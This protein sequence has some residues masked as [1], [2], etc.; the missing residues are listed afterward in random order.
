LS[1]PLSLS[2]IELIKNVDFVKTKFT[3][4]D[5]ILTYLIF[6]LSGITFFTQRKSFLLIA[7]LVM[8]LFFIKKNK[9]ID[10]VFFFI[11]FFQILI[12][13]GQLLFFQSFTAESFIGNLILWLLP[14]FYIKVSGLKF[15]KIYVDLMFIFTLIGFV[16]WIGINLSPS[17]LDLLDKMVKDLKLDPV[18]LENFIIYNTEH[19]RTGDIM[20][21]NPGP[22]NEGGTYATYLS[23]AIVLNLVQTGRLFDKRNIVFLIALLT[24][25]SSAGYIAFFFIISTYFLVNKKISFKVF[26]FPIIVGI[27]I[28]GFL[29][30]EFLSNKIIK[31]YESQTIGNPNLYRVGRFG[32]MIADIEQLQKYPIF[33][34]GIYTDDRYYSYTDILV[35]RTS[36]PM[37]ILA[38]TTRYG[39]IFGLIYFSTIF[40]SLKRINNLK[41]NNAFLVLVAFGGL[42]IT[43]SG[44]NPFLSSAYISLFYLYFYSDKPKISK[45]V[46]GLLNDNVNHNTKL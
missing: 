19:F 43:G 6:A 29:S 24:T 33:G 12:S 9:S 23:F 35:N 39:L 5:Y 34:R 17:F 20:I 46:L 25:F 2:K 26:V 15:I 16:F 40:L 30:I 8:F 4:E 3:F 14:Y 27:S 38:F 37:G 11:L 31:Q 13:L 10:G 1:I 28:Y 7:F 36:S 18:G 21:R 22:F 42:M 45:N 41:S 32:G 44:Q